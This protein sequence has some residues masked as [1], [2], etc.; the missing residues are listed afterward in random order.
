MWNPRM[1]EQY[2]LNLPQQVFNEDMGSEV[3][4]SARYRTLTQG[5]YLYAQQHQATCPQSHTGPHSEARTSGRVRSHFVWGQYHGQL[6]EV[7]M[8]PEGW[9][10]PNSQD[11][12]VSI[13]WD[14]DIHHTYRGTGC[15]FISKP[16]RYTYIYIYKLYVATFIHIHRHI[17][18]H[19]HI[20]ISKRIPKCLGLPPRLLNI[21]FGWLSFV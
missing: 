8:A 2:W 19:T 14:K 20:H 5:V 18:I 10:F 6:L 7:V 4:S 13:G 15:I 17:Q 1:N 12:I 3:V 21:S 11:D 9:W 16:F